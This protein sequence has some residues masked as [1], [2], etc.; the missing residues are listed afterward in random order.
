F[1]ITGHTN[2]YGAGG[3][4]FWLIKTDISGNMVWDRTFGGTDDDYGYSVQQTIDRGYIITGT[5]SS[6]GAGA[7]DVWLIKTDSNGSTVFSNSLVSVNNDSKLIMQNNI[8][9]NFNEFGLVINNAEPVVTSNLIANNLG[10]IKFIDS[11]PQF[12]MNNTMAD[13]D[14]ICLFFDGNSNPNIENNIIYGNGAEEIYI[15]DDDSDPLFQYNDIEGGILGFGLN[16]G[17]VYTGTYESN[18]NIDPLFVIDTYELQGASLCRDSGVPGITEDQLE[19]SHLPLTDIVGSP[20]LSGGEID[21]GAYEYYVSIDTP[22][23]PT[24]VITSVASNILTI[25]WDIMLNANSYL[26]YSSDD[27]Y[28]IFGYIETVSVNTWSINI[29]ADTKKFYYI[30]SSSATVKE[31]DISNVKNNIKIGDILR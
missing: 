22:E 27:P 20:R 23:S 31:N 30:I 8:I 14:S 2:S 28:G 12:I 4:D 6:Y 11:S 18:L 3:Y 21:M 16:T 1:I 5:T 15:N 19:A 9:N 29:D 24:N 10:G 7:M 25:D 13:N 26:V 17:V